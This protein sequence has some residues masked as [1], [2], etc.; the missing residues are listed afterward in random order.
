MSV[1]FSKKSQLGYLED[2]ISIFLNTGLFFLKFIVGQ[3]ARKL[4]QSPWW[5]MPG[6]HFLVPGFDSSYHRF[7]AGFQTT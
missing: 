5:L 3:K 7:L 4:V 2:Y 1:D 6:I